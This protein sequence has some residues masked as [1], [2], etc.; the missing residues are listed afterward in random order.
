[1]KKNGLFA[2]SEETLWLRPWVNWLRRVLDLCLGPRR[3]GGQGP[4]GHRPAGPPHGVCEA[5]RRLLPVPCAPRPAGSSPRG[6][7]R[8]RLPRPA[9]LASAEAGAPNACFPWSLRLCLSHGCPAGLGPGSDVS[10]LLFPSPAPQT[11]APRARAPTQDGDTGQ[12][13]GCTGHKVGRGRGYCA[14]RVRVPWAFQH[15]GDT[16]SQTWRSEIGALRQNPVSVVPQL[17]RLGVEISASEET[18]LP[19]AQT[20]TA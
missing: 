1:M 10:S 19:R 14:K 20:V 7:A 2:P 18:L 15:T 6:S 17:L 13:S 16:S 12:S 3:K 4:E 11:G 5:R 8:A 9:L